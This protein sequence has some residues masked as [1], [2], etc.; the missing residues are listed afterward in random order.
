MKPMPTNP[1]IALLTDF[2]LEDPF[3][4][5][6]KGV[7]AKLAPGTR[8]ID[9]THAIPQGDIQRAA[10]Q[11]W[12]TRPYFPSGTVFLTVVDPGVGTER[13]A[14]ITR[15]DKYTYIGP[16]NGIFSYIADESSTAW[17][18]SNPKYQLAQSSAT[19]HGRDIFAPA[20]AHAAIG[21]PAADFG[22][23]VGD[24]IRL[25][26]P[27]LQIY[28]DRIIGETIYVDHFGNLLTSLGKFIKSG[29]QGY[30]FEPWLGV[31]NEFTSG[32]EI[33]VDR[34]TLLL[35]DG[36]ILNWVETFAE[37][38]NGDCGIL[39]GSTG[40]IEIAALNQSAQELTNL[41]LGATVTL[42]F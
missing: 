4:G 3:V 42:L 5:I 17:E 32:F 37:I 10:V 23:P 26:K 18:L 31:N 14:I 35:S 27:K 24:I 30:K 19:F 41:S 7:I 28:S 36:A 38:P 29:E 13:K 33:Q 34:A 20:A 12:M 1:V 15:D 6:M 25:Q 22:L 21:V 8:I 40:L 39:V 11:L 2:V 9:I 16:D